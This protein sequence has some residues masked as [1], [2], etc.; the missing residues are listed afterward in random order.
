MKVLAVSSEYPSS[1]AP[2]RASFN[3][4]HLNALAEYHDVA[5]FCPVAWRARLAGGWAPIAA[6]PGVSERIRVAYATYLYPPGVA[7]GSYDSWMWYSLR[8]A[9]LRFAQDVNP[10]IVLGIWGFPDGAVAVRLARHLDLP[11]AAQ[12]LGSDINLLDD[13]PAKR[14]KTLAALRQATGVITVSRALKAS[15]MQLGID[16]RQVT[17][18]YRGVNAALFAPRD[19]AVSQRHLGLDADRRHLLFIGNLVAVKNPLLLLRAFAAARFD[20]GIVLHVIGQGGLRA[21]LEAVAST[22]GPGKEV[23]FHGAVP[24]ADIPAWLAAVDCLVLTSDAEGVPN[25]L[26]EARS[27]GC[28]YIATDVGGV[29]EVSEHAS[30][31]VVPPGDL[32]ALRRALEAVPGKRAERVAAPWQSWSAAGERLANELERLAT[33]S[34]DVRATATG[35]TPL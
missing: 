9:L 22:V 33:R 8:R 19:R 5:V 20:D 23:V 26:L 21:D 3:R 34:E 12:L 14:Q 11:V 28:P 2:H 13:Y 6:P 18:V 16:E 30:A 27:M 10:D 24:H 25:V 15:V 31:T 35:A 1:L 17:V 4:Q 7:R 29:A 32:N